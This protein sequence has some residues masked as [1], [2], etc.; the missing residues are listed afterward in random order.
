MPIDKEL[1]ERLAN[2]AVTEVTEAEEK[3]LKDKFKKCQ[4]NIRQFEKEQARIQGD[5]D[6]QKAEIEAKID[7]IK[8]AVGKAKAGEV[9]ALDALPFP[10]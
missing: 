8:G 4:Y 3:A 9:E 7:E 5:A 6:K 10:G 1:A 2:E